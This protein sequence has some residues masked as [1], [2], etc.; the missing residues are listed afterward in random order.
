MENISEN[1]H[2][3][4]L[5][6]RAKEAMKQ[7]T[8]LEYGH[9]EKMDHSKLLEELNIYHIELEMQH[10]EL[11]QA[12]DNL[13]QALKYRTQLFEKAPIGY[14]IMDLAGIVQEANRTF[15]NYM[16]IRKDFLVG[17]RFQ[18]FVTQTHFMKYHQA[19][20]KMMQDRV[21]GY[22]EVELTRPN[23]PWFWVRLDFQFMD[24][25]GNEVILCSV[26]NISNEKKA[27]EQLS[28]FNLQ[29][30]EQV[31]QRTVALQDANQSLKLEIQDRK[32]AEK[33]ATDLAEK[34]TILLRELHHRVKNNMQ[35]VTSLLNLQSRNMTDTK[36]LAALME[37]QHR[38]RSLA[39]IH[40]ILYQSD[41][42]DFI[43][44]K[45]YLKKIIRHLA[46][47][48]DIGKKDI[49]IHGDA[50]LSK[51]HIDIAIPLGLI[52]TELVTNSIKH[53]FPN[54][55][56]GKIFVT[57][58]PANYPATSPLKY[59]AMEEASPKPADENKNMELYRLTVRDNG[60]GLAGGTDMDAYHTLG[61][62]LV[63]RLALDQLRGKL[64]VTTGI[65]TEVSLEFTI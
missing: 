10:D 22:V 23:T 41:N 33:K 56:A 14:F 18:S 48:Y 47:A 20:Q 28:A 52:L 63:Q 53:A 51:V 16:G 40:E 7:L 34:Q 3:T 24:D 58:A 8:T 17:K 44:F 46:V 60:T 45:I 15:V 11:R 29:L 25:P 2:M 19:M 31:A 35:I 39:I 1:K 42:L 64:Y 65:G 13:E 21:P 61:F 59:P 30:E 49:Q 38:I 62:K 54:G 37:S 36:A 26:L 55:G 50:A 12:R 5:R 6:E 27:R 57:L 4:A 9:G 32:T 43:P